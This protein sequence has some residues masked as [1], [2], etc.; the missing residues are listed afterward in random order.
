[1]AG[2]D[3]EPAAALQAQLGA[4]AEPEP[5]RPGR[6]AH[7]A[8][9]HPQRQLPGLAAR[10]H[11]LRAAGVHDLADGRR[12]HLQPGGAVGAAASHRGAA[13]AG[14]HHTH[15]RVS[16]G[17]AYCRSDPGGLRI[18]REGALNEE[19]E[20]VVNSRLQDVYI[21]QQM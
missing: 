7:A 6:P 11:H 1:M 3:E 17:D 19:S 8:L 9:R 14:A 15:A 10:G 12:G 2:P 5:G 20:W 4:A 16:M 18:A 21:K 13:H